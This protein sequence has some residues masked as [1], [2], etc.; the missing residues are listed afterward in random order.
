VGEFSF[1]LYGAAVALQ[2][3]PKED[4]AILA[5]AVALSMFLTPVLAFI[6]EKW[7]EPKLSKRSKMEQDKIED[8]KPTVIIAGFGRFG[9]IVGRLLYANRIPATVLDF[10]PDQIELLRRFGFKVYYGDATRIDLLEA[11]GIASAKVLVVAID[12]VE[13]SLK[14]IDLVKSHF[15]HLKIFARARNVQHVYDLYDRQV[16]VIER[17]TFEASLKMGSELL[18]HLGWPAYQAQVAANK[19]RSHNYKMLKDL[20]QSRGDQTA[21]VAKAKQARQ[22]LEEMFAQDTSQLK[23]T[24]EGW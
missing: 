9:Q 4:S 16:D 15:P 10:E 11:A 8:E 19:F 3:L 22:D 13:E 14:L 18:N 21:L 5:A 17:E 2:I 1:V 20:H 7:V 24:D 12:N 23:E 6:Y